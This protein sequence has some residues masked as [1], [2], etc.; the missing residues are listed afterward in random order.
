[1]PCR[2][3]HK[4]SGRNSIVFLADS[5]A[6]RDQWV[7]AIA[8]EIT[9]LRAPVVRTEAPNAPSSSNAAHATASAL[10]IFVQLPC[11]RKCA[12]CGA[13]GPR[14]ASVTHRVLI[15]VE[16][17]GVHRFVCPAANAPRG[18]AHAPQKPWPPH[19]VR[20]GTVQ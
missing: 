11:N 16:C 10:E 19:I 17:A 18:C 12:D 7:K 13:E 6:Q 8:A 14:W 15:C 20:P 3:S 9:A 2:Y 1:M 5:P 4:I